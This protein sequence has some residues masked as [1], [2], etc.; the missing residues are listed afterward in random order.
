LSIDMDGKVALVTGGAT[1]IGRGIAEAFAELGAQVSVLEIDPA[2]VDSVRQA[3]SGLGS[4]APVQVGDASDVDDVR[5]WVA[6]IGERFGRI[7]TLVNN[8]GST[9]ARRQP[10]SDTTEDDWEALYQV[11]LRHMFVST[12]AALPLLRAA[13]PG[14]TII[15]LSSIEAFRGIP[16]HVAYG[17]FKAAV[18]GFTKSLALELGPE[19]IRVNAIAPETTESEAVPVSRWLGPGR[20][21]RVG[22]WIPLGRFGQP[23][24]AAGCAVFLATELSSWVTGTTIHLDGGAFAA[25]G[26]V[27]TPDS[28][29]TNAPVI[30]G[31][32]FTPTVA[33]LPGTNL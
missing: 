28:A 25:S 12:R 9:L 7:D 15:N 1:G 30:A 2:R 17:S 16:R 4:E 19:G 33:P 11:N 27:Q 13:G 21:D 3:L 6:A 31:A 18:T 10:F 20:S 14:S 32:G 22:H 29:W 26:W 5:R 23:R 24:D 8:V